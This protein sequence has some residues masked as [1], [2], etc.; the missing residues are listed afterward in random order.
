MVREKCSKRSENVSVKIH[1]PPAASV[2]RVR[3][4]MRFM[5]ARKAC[6]IYD[7]TF[8]KEYKDS[9]VFYCTSIIQFQQ[10]QHSRAFAYRTRERQPTVGCLPYLS[11]EET[12]FCR[13]T[14]SRTITSEPRRRHEKTETGRGSVDGTTPHP[15]RVRQHPRLVLLEREATQQRINTYLPNRTKAGRAHESLV[16]S[17]QSIKLCPSIQSRQYDVIQDR[18][19]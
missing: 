14:E 3:E 12:K 4:K 11:R 10:A 13:G 9:F 5:D 8:N 1:L 6:Y 2:L 7:C 17:N 15:G 18:R 16:S 19:Q